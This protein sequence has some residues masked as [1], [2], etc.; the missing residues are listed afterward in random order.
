MEMP[1]LPN[2]ASTIESGRQLGAR[3]S[4]GDIVKITGDL[5]AG[6]TTFVRGIVEGLGGNP[7]QVHSPT[8]TIVHVYES[9]TGLINHCDF[10]RLEP[11]SELQEFGGL[12]FF[13][14][15][16]IF[17]L[18]WPERV[19]LFQYITRDRLI[20][21]HLE[22]DADGRFLRISSTKKIFD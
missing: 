6:K 10:Y 3:L 15:E 13:D 2:E 17:L 12:E 9:P 21:V 8:F 18:E 1:F 19:G 16:K 11:R 14:E 4:P 7:D 22:H 5:G 20:D